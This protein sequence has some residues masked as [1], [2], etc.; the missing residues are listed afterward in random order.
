MTGLGSGVA[1][2]FGVEGLMYLDKR[3]GLLVDAQ[4]GSAWLGGISLLFRQGGRQ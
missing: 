2:H 4:V 3:W 1:G